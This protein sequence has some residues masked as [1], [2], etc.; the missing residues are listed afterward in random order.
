[1]ELVE[2]ICTT[3]SP[4]KRSLSIST[5]FLEGWRMDGG[6]QPVLSVQRGMTHK[7]GA[8]NLGPHS[9]GKFMNLDGRTTS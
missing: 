8:P 2:V 1:M 4:H 3:W 7:S 9:Y 6:V 5:S